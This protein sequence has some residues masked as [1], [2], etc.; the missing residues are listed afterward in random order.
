MFP[1]DFY[2]STTTAGK[3]RKKNLSQDNSLNSA[4][5]NI[6]SLQSSSRWDC[7]NE[8]ASS[9]STTFS[10]PRTFKHVP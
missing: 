1:S 7:P 4:S 8:A 3:Y 2:G 5:E 9:P 6:I 10:G